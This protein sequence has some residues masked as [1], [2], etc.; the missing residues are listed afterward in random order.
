MGLVKVRAAGWA[1]AAWIRSDP[2][3]MMPST[4]NRKLE[5]E[6]IGTTDYTEKTDEERR[7]C[8]KTT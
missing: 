2:S 6:D 7:H 1:W 5:N 8:A 3:R 4:G